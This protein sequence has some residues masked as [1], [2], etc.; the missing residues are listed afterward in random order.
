M[1]CYKFPKK[2]KKTEGFSGV[3]RGIKKE[4]REEIG[5]KIK[6]LFFQ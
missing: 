6:G 1:V 5:W 3:F 4:H 2:H